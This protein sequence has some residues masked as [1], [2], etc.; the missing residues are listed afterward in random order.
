M[1]TTVLITLFCLFSLLGSS[2][3]NLQ[4]HF[5]N[6]GSTNGV[7]YQML[8]FP[9]GDLL[10]HGYNDGGD[11]DPGPGVNTSGLSCMFA[12]Y[13]PSGSLVFGRPLSYNGTQPNIRSLVDMDDDGNFY[14]F[15]GGAGTY[16]LDP[17]PGVGE[18]TV[19]GLTYA[20]VKFDS[21]GNYKWG[22]VYNGNIT[23]TQVKAISN[24]NVIISGT[25]DFGNADLDPGPGYFPV[26]SSSSYDGFVAKFD[27]S[28]NFINAATFQSTDPNAFFWLIRLEVDDLDNIYVGGPFN[29][30]FDVNPGP[31][32]FN[33]NGGST[34]PYQWFLVKLN[35]NMNFEYGYKFP[36]DIGY[37]ITADRYNH[38]YL[39]GS[40]KGT[41]DVDLKTGVT[42]I[43]SPPNHHCF[44][45]ARY[46]SAA[47][48]KWV[49]TMQT[50]SGY[51]GNWNSWP[52]TDD[53]GNLNFELY[54]N[55]TIVNN[56]FGFPQLPN[57]GF[58]S[59]GIYMTQIDTS[60]ASPFIIRLPENQTPRTLM[61]DA[62]HFYFSGRVY[63]PTD[64][65]IG[66]GIMIDSPVAGSEYFISY[67][68]RDPSLNRI[69][70]KA[71]VDVNNNSVLD[72][73]ETRLQNLV[74]N[75][76]TGNLFV[77][78]DN[79]GNYSSY[80]PPGNYSMSIPSFPSYLTGPI[81]LVHNATFPAANQIDSLN[82]FA[83]GVD[84]AEM[85]VRVHITSSGP[86]R[87]GMP[88]NYTITF[89]NNS[90][91][92]QSGV[93][94]VVLDS[95]VSLVN[96]TLTPS[97]VNGQT[98]Q[99]NYSGL[100]ML[101]SQNIHLLVMVD[102]TALMGDTILT[103]ADITPVTGDANPS[104]N[105]DTSFVIVISSYDPNSKEVSPS[106][107]I[108]EAQVTNGL[109]LYYTIRFQN[110]GNDTA[111]RVVILDT[112]SGLLDITTLEIVSMSHSGF[113]ALHPGNL[114]EFRFDNILLP[115][116]NINEP[117]SHG[118]IKYKIR[119]LNSL[120]MGSIIENAAHIYFD[121]N[122]PIATNTTITQVV[123]WLGV[124][125]GESVSHSL[126]YPNPF[127]DLL[128]FKLHNNYDIIL[129]VEL[130]DLSGRRIFYQKSGT[131]S[132]SVDGSGLPSGVYFLKIQS[133]DRTETFRVVK[134]N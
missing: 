101:Q 65:Q 44:F 58:A 62:N 31:Q 103:V 60:G 49:K 50:Q 132:G 83:F 130:T 77:S 64:I 100:A 30:M 59:A 133:R 86:A 4:W 45:I 124:N 74:V 80:V 126:V 39:S 25:F 35:S 47:N 98:L 128:N 5:N 72:I 85:D 104:N 12:R 127:S 129:S 125:Q 27:S 112:L 68:S 9:N 75:F 122:T 6:T 134:C 67:Y 96:T 78:T 113:F 24:N 37:Y 108:T 95:A 106:T 56:G 89:T 55:D 23:L 84:P 111:F 123:D 40:F 32:T 15:F 131:H 1:K 42:N 48:L 36:K 70:G 3:T 76:G 2:Q 102:S 21:M 29:G 91:I 17:A 26:V 90:F 109:D 121:F 43:S 116:S 13:T 99:W 57:N 71:F 34:N 107:A 94:T 41:I 52:Y 117:G 11:I 10:I 110:T 28:G 7:V 114:M 97:I 51:T 82:D 81:P 66:P 19:T 92:S 69:D 38:I 20:F 87:P 120:L 63:G 46:D 53:E 88:F 61:T 79:H 119:P 73:N 93:V 33:I 22:F 16:D 8:N 105:T 54:L 18:L 115:D 118:F 14:F